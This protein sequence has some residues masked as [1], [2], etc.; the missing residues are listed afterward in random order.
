VCTHARRCTAARVGT[1][2]STVIITENGSR[3]QKRRRA[4][5]VGKPRWSDRFK[6]PADMR[7][8][9]RFL[10]ARISRAILL[11][12]PIAI[13]LSLSLSLSHGGVATTIAPVGS[14]PIRNSIN[15]HFRV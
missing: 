12:D 11:R 1:D 2:N 13:L 4:D 9:K 3:V 6:A 5:V 10:V 7:Q 15:L 14:L 8:E